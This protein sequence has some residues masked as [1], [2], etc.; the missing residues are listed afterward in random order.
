[1]SKYFS[2]DIVNDNDPILFHETLEQA[3]QACLENAL[4]QYEYAVEID[5]IIDEFEDK[6]SEAVYGKIL[7]HCESKKRSPDKDDTRESQYDYII[8]LP[9]LIEHNGWISVDERL[10]EP[11]QRVEIYSSKKELQEECGQQFETL[12]STA[13]FES[14][15]DDDGDLRQYFAVTPRISFDIE[16]VTHWQPLSEPPK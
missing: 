11:E 7:G 6:I 9:E 1:M 12:T 5:S 13:V 15:V 2:V 14:W 4:N 16:D 3:K 8:D 10:P